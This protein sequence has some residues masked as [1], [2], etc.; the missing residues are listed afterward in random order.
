MRDRP[1]A[2]GRPSGSPAVNESQTFPRDGRVA[3]LERD[4]KSSAAM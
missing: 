4:I 3:V 2:N 1:C